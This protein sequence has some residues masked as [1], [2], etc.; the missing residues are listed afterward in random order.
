MQAER[1]T[2]SVGSEWNV[3]FHKFASPRSGPTRDEYIKESSLALRRMVK[4]DARMRRLRVRK[5]KLGA[6]LYLS[7]P[8][9][10]CMMQRRCAGQLALACLFLP[11]RLKVIALCYR[12][13]ATCRKMTD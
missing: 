5:E 8:P 6:F 12:G 13:K 10:L 4:H 3:I 1:S 11:A 9:D 7:C 2:V